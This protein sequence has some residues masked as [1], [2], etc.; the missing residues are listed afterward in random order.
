MRA[1]RRVVVTGV[2]LTSPVGLNAGQ[3]WA[4]LLEGRSGVGPITHFDTTDFAVK[5]A[6]E[7]TGFDPLVHLGRKD[8]KKMDRFIHFGIAAAFEALED[9][10]LERPVPEPERTGTIVGVGLGGLQSLEN[11]LDVLR[12]RGPKRVSPFDIPRL[13]PNLGAGHVSIL[14][15]AQGPQYAAVSAC[16]SA[17]HSIGAA[18]RLI[19]YGDAEVIIAGG[20]DATVTPMGVAGFAAMKAL[21]TRNEDPEAA[22]RPWDEGR[23]GFVMAE[24][25]GILIL[26]EL[27]HAKARGAR[28]YGELLGYGQSSDAHHMTL[29]EPTGRGARTAMQKA[30]ADAGVNAGE[31]D[32]VNAH[33]TSTPMGDTAE[34]KAIQSV[35]GAHAEQVWVSS[36][37]SMTGHALGAAGGIEAVISLLALH[38]GKV[39][40][41]INLTKPSAECVLDYVPQTARE[42]PLRNVISNSFGFGGTNVSLLFGALS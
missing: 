18:A 5:I 4:N 19:A 7:V 34:S 28:I 23:D 36:T 32:Y 10:G 22:S 35:F 40:P 38:H 21:S 13:I 12:A 26:E 31:V 16:A 41:T 9:A 24:G 42:R 2:G 11:A 39:P 6:G 1:S 15:G 20:T 8:A 25:A 37:K 27:E 29:P 14:C 30:L 17:A 33:G 3:S